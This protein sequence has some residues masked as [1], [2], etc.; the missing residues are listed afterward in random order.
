MDCMVARVIPQRDPVSVL[1]GRESWVSQHTVE[2]LIRALT[3][4]PSSPGSRQRLPNSEHIRIS[5]PQTAISSHHF[6]CIQAST[7]EAPL[8]GEKI[9]HGLQLPAHFPA[10]SVCNGYEIHGELI[11]YGELI[12][13]DGVIV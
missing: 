7:L 12:E 8:P 5:Q 1:A 10:G 2:F 11:V 4:R 13:Y 3:Q 9:C 6:E